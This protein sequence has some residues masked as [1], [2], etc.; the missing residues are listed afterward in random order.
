MRS[1][2]KAIASVCIMI[3]APIFSVSLNAEP[4]QN[5][6]VNGINRLPARATSYSY[7]TEADALTNNREKSRMTS[8][9]GVWKFHFAEDV[10]AAPDGFH[11]SGYD[12]SGWSEIE[13]PSCWEMQ[14]FGYPIY[15]NTAAYI[16]SNNYQS[17]RQFN[18]DYLSGFICAH[19]CKH[20]TRNHSKY[21]APYFFF[22]Q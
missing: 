8:L 14:G 6:Y 18:I 3:L 20:Y 15:T 1:Y 11:K 7:A 13:V 16:K 22:T 9:N 21:A 4:W 2:V 17:Q 10:S 12:V 19:P 5:Q